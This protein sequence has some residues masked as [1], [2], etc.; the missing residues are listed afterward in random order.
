MKAKDVTIVFLF[1]VLLGSVYIGY[2]MWTEVPDYPNL[3]VEYMD[4][5]DEYQIVVEELRISEGREVNREI[6]VEER[7]EI[8]KAYLFRSSMRGLGSY[9][10]DQGVQKLIVF[11]RA[12]SWGDGVFRALEEEFRGGIVYDQRYSTGTSEFRILDLQTFEK[13]ELD[14]TTAVLLISYTEAV[15]IVRQIEIPIDWY[16]VNIEDYA[17][18]LKEAEG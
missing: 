3:E 5:Q 9:L 15:E 17:I 2:T 18:K 4:L 8:I 14:N 6:S 10:T 12:D 16:G 1:V 7:E 11:R 13:I